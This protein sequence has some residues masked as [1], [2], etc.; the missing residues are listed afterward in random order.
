MSMGREQTIVPPSLHDTDFYSW[1]GEQAKLLRAGDLRAVDLI[2]IAEELETLGRSE[3]T[4]LRSSL[5][6]VVMHLLKAIHQPEKAGRSWLATIR[7]ERIN[8]ERSLKDN[9]GLKSRL[10]VLFM[11]AYEDG[12]EEALNE[13][14]LAGM[15]EEPELTLHQVRDKTFIPSSLASCDGD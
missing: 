5:R 8:V 10:V 1:T 3:A 14:G 2:N 7:R 11:E 9:P 12:R 15:L 6:L 4:A 13:T